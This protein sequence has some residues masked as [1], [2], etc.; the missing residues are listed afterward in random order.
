MPPSELKRFRSDY[1][2]SGEYSNCYLN[3]DTGDIMVRAALGP[4]VAPAWCGNPAAALDSI[5]G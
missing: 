4:P 5:A 1:W 2:L 3:L